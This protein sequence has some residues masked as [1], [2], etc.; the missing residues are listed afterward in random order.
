M[1]VKIIDA[2]AGE[3]HVDAGLGSPDH[4]GWDLTDDC[5]ISYGQDGDGGDWIVYLAGPGD[6]EDLYVKVTREQL[7]EH[8]RHILYVIDE[9]DR[10][11]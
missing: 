5:K 4:A 3:P 6:S 11:R 1:N 8:A 10:T 9:K 2:P 7:A